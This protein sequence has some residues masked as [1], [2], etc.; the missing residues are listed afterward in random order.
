M[1]IIKNKAAIQKMHTAGQL[2]ARVLVEIEEY[3]VVGVT[4]L[5]I[6]RKIEEKMRTAGLNP[7]CKGYGGY[8]YATCISLNNAVIHG[9]PS[10]KVV[11]KNGDFV[12]IDVVG[13]YKGY[14][15]DMTRQFFVGIVIDTVKQLAATAQAALDAA[16][17]IIRPGINLSDI[18]AC[19]QEE[20]EENGFGVVRDFAGHG[21]GKAIHEDPEIPNFGR[22]GEGPILR[23]GMTFAIEPMITEKNYAVKRAADGW[24]ILT[25]D[26]GLAAHV[27]DT[28]VVLSDG[29]QV[30]TRL[31]A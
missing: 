12:K 19:I 11:L 10:D 23:E 8:C 15:A 27:E 5:E 3:V 9:L 20:V 31:S 2:L 28:I 29:V 7:V 30:L 17:A 21:I 18:S 25:K 13:A 14:C 24:T 26:G 4:T 6:D 1:I 16:I 22:P